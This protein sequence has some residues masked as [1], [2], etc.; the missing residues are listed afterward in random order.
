MVKGLAQAISLIFHPLL[1]TTYVLCIYLLVNPFAF[2]SN[3][4]QREIPLI[5]MVFSL[6]FVIPAVVVIMSKKL[7]LVNSLTLKT[8]MER[9]IPYIA[10]AIFYLWLY[11]TTRSNPE[12]PALFKSFVLGAI[13]SL[14]LLFF[15]NNFSKISAHTS[16]MGGMLMFTF[17]LIGSRGGAYDLTPLLGGWSESRPIIL[18]IAALLITGLVASSRLWLRAHSADEVYG[19]FFVGCLGQIIALRIYD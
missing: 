3:T 1:I 15:I 5:M 14:F 16:G 2:G 12:I 9:V 17:L 11:I 18:P 6:T 10:T 7:G 13:I 19:G 8:K 4:I